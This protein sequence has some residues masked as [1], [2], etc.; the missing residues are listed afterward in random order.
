M[1]RVCLCGIHLLPCYGEGLL[2]LDLTYS[3][4]LDACD[5][6]FIN[7]F[8][9]CQLFYFFTCLLSKVEKTGSFCTIY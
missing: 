2:Q 9:D 6:Y 1:W 5:S 4:A 7:Q 3:N 8:I